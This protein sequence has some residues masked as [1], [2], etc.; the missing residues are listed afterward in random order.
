VPEL[1]EVETIRKQLAQEIVG[2]KLK[3]KEIIGL[4]RRAKILMIDFDDGSSLIFHLKMTGQLIFNQKP[5]PY[6]RKVFI[7]DDNSKL[8]FNDKRK[9][10]WHRKVKNTKKIEEKFGPEALEIN[11]KIFNNFLKKRPNAKIKNLLM[12]QT[13]IAGIGNIYSDEILFASKV[14]PLRQVKTLKEEEIKAIYKNIKKILKKAIA[15]NGSSVGDYFDA[16]GKKGSYAKYH[17]V[18]QKHGKECICCRDIIKRIKIGSRSAHY[19]P[20]CQT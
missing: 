11:L 3:G 4:R 2:K 20:N 9:F 1:P 12:D 8:F 13:F 5:S 17:R 10:G 16:F 15:E 19:C 7:F 6:T 14:R 18:Y